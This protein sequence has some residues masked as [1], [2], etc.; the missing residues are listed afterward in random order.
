MLPNVT[1][2]TTVRTPLRIGFFA[3]SFFPIVGGAETVLHNLATRLT[4][5]GDDVLVLAPHVR[6]SDNRMDVPYS[7]KRYSRPSS[8]R[9]GVS[10]LLLPLAWHQWQHQ[11][12]VLHCNSAYP[13]AYL[14]TTLR[15]WTNLPVVVRPHGDDILPNQR[16][17]RH[18]K[19]AA[20]A[21]QALC[22]ADAIVAQGQFL[23]RALLN[24]GVPDSLIHVIHNGVD[25]ALFANGEPFPHR[26]PYLLAMGSLFRRK[27]FDILL[28]A[29]ARIRGDEVDLLIAGDGPELHRLTEL[30][31]RLGASNQVRF[32]RH[33]SGQAKI[34]L[35]RSALFLVAPSRCEPFANAILEGLAS[36][37]PIV[38]SEVDG[39]PELVHP[40]RNGVLF[41]NED[42]EALTEQ[43][44][45]LIDVPTE[46]HLLR[47]GAIPSVRQFDWSL[48]EEQYSSLYRSVVRGYSAASGTRRYGLTG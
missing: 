4:I 42:V 12:D 17:C 14:G 15:D 27:G 36:G 44:Q 19:L 34:N 16:I 32:L 31:N 11:F 39:N 40:D 21:K 37:L 25:L 3:D 7:L 13:S 48:I 20:L 23:R 6:G 1:T 8:K 24:F 38:A 46:L 18:P 28:E 26:R 33:V 29:F 10:Q 43:L 2:S 22:R 47:K 45:R 30:A 35:L 9:F 5:K 41:P